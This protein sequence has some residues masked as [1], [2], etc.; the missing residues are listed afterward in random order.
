M[1]KF[2][3][4]SFNISLTVKMLFGLHEHIHKHSPYFNSPSKFGVVNY[5]P[6]L[7]VALCVPTSGWFIYLCVCVYDKFNCDQVV[8]TCRRRSIF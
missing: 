3:L 7:S 4:K 6:T 5:F 1:F 2:L 8:N